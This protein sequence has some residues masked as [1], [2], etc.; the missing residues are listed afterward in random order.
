M[1]EKMRKGNGMV[2]RSETTDPVITRGDF[3]ALMI[4]E[5]RTLR[6]YRNL[7]SLTVVL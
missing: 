3:M 1:V 6:T 4:S 5:Q 2:K 7:V